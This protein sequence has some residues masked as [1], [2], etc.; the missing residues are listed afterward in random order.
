MIRL[1]PTSERR[2]V[3]ASFLLTSLQSQQSWVSPWHHTGSC[4]SALTLTIPPARTPFPQICTQL[5]SRDSDLRLSPKCP[6][7]WPVWLMLAMPLLPQEI[8]TYDSVSPLYHNLEWLCWFLQVYCLHPPT[9]MWALEGSGLGRFH[10][11][12]LRSCLP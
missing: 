10:W 1:Q 12:S 3:P 4:L 11:G 6:P 2:L 8:Q 7:P 5:A 9:T